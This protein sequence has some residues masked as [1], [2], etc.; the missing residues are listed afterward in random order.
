MGRRIVKR[1]SVVLIR[2]PFT[3]LSGAK[4][5][6]AIIITPDE[7]LKRINDVLY[8]FIFSVVPEKNR[9]LPMDFVIES[10]MRHTPTKSPLKAKADPPENL[11]ATHKQIIENMLM[12]PKVT[13]NELADITGKTRETIR[14]HIKMLKEMKLIKRIGPHKGGH[15]EIIS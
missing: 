14:V 9:L 8:L 15:W 10:E 1:G 11:L 7:F 2:Y 12:N 6:P 5:R 13:Y 3:D 4:V